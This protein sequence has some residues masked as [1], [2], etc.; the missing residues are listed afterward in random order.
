MNQINPNW[1]NKTQLQSS[2][3]TYHGVRFLL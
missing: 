1:L 2:W 3:I